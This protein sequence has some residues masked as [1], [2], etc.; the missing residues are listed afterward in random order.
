MEQE[1][2]CGIIDSDIVC[3]IRKYREKQSHKLTIAFIDYILKEIESDIVFEKI[4]TEKYPDGT[5]K[6]IKWYCQ[7]SE[8]YFIEYGEDGDVT[9]M[10]CFF[11][12]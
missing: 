10:G 3:G 8:G 12:V 7:P 4:N 6:G 5:L 11:S 2:K 9:M 1:N